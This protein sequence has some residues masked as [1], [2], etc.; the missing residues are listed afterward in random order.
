MTIGSPMHEAGH[1]K[2]VLWDNPEGYGGWG[3]GTQEWERG[4]R[5]GGHMNIHGQF[6][7]IYDKNQHNIAK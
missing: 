5:R 3:S 1:S 7:L 4:L 2:S 6:M